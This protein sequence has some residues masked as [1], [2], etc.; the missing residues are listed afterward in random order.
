MAFESSGTILYVAKFRISRIPG[1]E[2]VWARPKFYTDT[3]TEAETRL[4]MV[5]VFPLQAM[6]AHWGMWMQG[7]TYM[8][9]WHWDK[10]GW[11]VPILGCLLLIL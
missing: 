8:Q 4:K 1:L 2:I 6:K 9:P 7:Y 11:L 5:N 3:H 10:D